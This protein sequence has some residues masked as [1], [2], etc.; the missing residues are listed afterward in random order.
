MN[1]LR[2]Q[3]IPVTVVAILV[4]TV[5]SGVLH[6]HL[7]R[8]WGTHTD[9][10]A[11]GERLDD[12][13]A[14]IGPWQMDSSGD[15]DAEVQEILRCD[16]SLKRSY[17]NVETGASVTVA[18]LL[19]PAGPI[20]VHT[21]EICYSSRD[22]EIVGSKEVATLNAASD[23]PNKF[24]V[25]KF[26]G[27]SLAEENLRVYYGWSTGEGWIAAESARF[28]FS[29]EPWL[30]KIQVAGAVPDSQ[31]P[32]SDPCRDFL[33]VFVPEIQNVLASTRE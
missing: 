6:G 21:P 23:V 27:R 9:V 32:E 7:S 11:F 10:V 5:L 29:G 24:W 19:G 12:V 3:R 4:A 33:E 8:R 20:A 13:P 26:R 15:L 14:R 28:E 31:P 17:I 25:S 18:L 1:F 16:G 22:Y 2:Q 30:Y